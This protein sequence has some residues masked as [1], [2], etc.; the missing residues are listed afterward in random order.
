MLARRVSRKLEEGNFRGAVNAVRSEDVI[1][2]FS[3]STLDALRIKHPYPH[4]DRREFQAPGNSQSGLEFEVQTVYNAVLSFP[5][6]SADGLSPQHLKDLL[7]ADGN[8][9]QLA[10]G[11]T[12]FTNIVA[13]GGVPG[14]IQPFVFGARLTAFLKKDGGLRPI[15]VGL[16]LRR[17][18]AKV[19][20]TYATSSLRTVLSPL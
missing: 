4:P 16:T 5:H 13:R 2:P 6:G 17:L 19:I 11:L 10:Q 15:A 9:G 7:K 18:I 1:A 8:V 20:A 12:S 14:F 3:S